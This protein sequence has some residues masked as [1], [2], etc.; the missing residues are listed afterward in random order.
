[1]PIQR[2]LSTVVDVESGRVLLLELS[3]Q[4]ELIPRV[5]DDAGA[6]TG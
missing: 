3:S 6:Q 2:R 4:L 5:R 1:V